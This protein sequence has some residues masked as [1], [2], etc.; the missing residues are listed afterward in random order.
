MQHIDRHATHWP[1]EKLQ[2]FYS[3]RLIK[4][5]FDVLMIE[6]ITTK[7]AVN[8]K[9][10]LPVSG[11]PRSSVRTLHNDLCTLQ[12]TK[13]VLC[14]LKFCQ[15]LCKSDIYLCASS[16]RL[17]W[18]YTVTFSYHIHY[19]LL[20]N[21]HLSVVRLSQVVIVANFWLAGCHCWHLSLDLSRPVDIIWAMMIVWCVS[22]GTWNLNPTSQS[23][24]LTG[25]FFIDWWT[26]WLLDSRGN[27]HWC[28]YVDWSNTSTR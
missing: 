2:Y 6:K 10:I 21:H 12:V 28:L 9:V 16:V 8:C 13:S 5:L 26:D 20:F 18:V 19:T 23:T 22:S 3:D 14:W 7:S 24:S 1:S 17:L 25:S 27:R 11:N 15:V 4:W